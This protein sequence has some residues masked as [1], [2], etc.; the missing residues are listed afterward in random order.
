MLCQHGT[1]TVVD[2]EAVPELLPQAW[3]TTPLR[4]ISC[5]E[6][7]GVRSGRDPADILREAIG[8][9][10]KLPVGRCKSGLSP[11][12]PY[13]T[14]AEL[15][16]LCAAAS[17]HRRC[18]LTTHVAESEA[19]F[20]MFSHAKGSMY[21]WLAR[22]GRN[23]GDCGEGSPV[24]YLARLGYLKA[25]LLAVH[26][27]Y[28]GPEDARIL[29]EH[30]TSVVHCP[31]SHAYF[32][33]APF[34]FEELRA[35][36]VNVALGTDSLAS[37][38]CAGEWEGSS[39]PV[40][41]ARVRTGT[42]RSAS[43]PDPGEP[44]GSVN[45][46]GGDERMPVGRSVPDRRTGRGDHAGAVRRDAEPCRIGQVQ[47]KPLIELDLFAEMRAF[48]AVHPE[49]DP[50]WVLGMTTRNG[51]V[52]KV[53]LDSFSNPRVTGVN[54]INLPKGDELIEASLTDGT[55]DIVLATRNGMAIRFHEEKVRAMG[56]S[57]YG[58]KGINLEKGDECMGMVIIRRDSS[59]LVV[60]ENGYGKRSAISDYRV[61][62]RGGKGVINVKTSDRN[63]KVVSI[64][65][66]IDDDELILI[67]RKGIA[68]RQSVKQIKV[69]GR[70]T[71]GVR[72]I[73]LGKDDKVIDV[74]RLAIGD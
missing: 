66:V 54:A 52:K 29:G 65:E 2:I 30:G 10:D 5:L 12:A 47:P 9:L 70:N 71:Q 8:H 48:R 35:A 36:G 62:N 58:V 19:E 61:T 23:M 7:T 18:V 34:P 57:A 39:N 3:S 59:I 55:N 72:L 17:I 63:G 68:N 6:L 67:T 73:N 33:H 40:D 32:G 26:V 1:T 13:S 24:R 21:R 43:L 4:V 31:R 44:P 74:A 20:A 14:G 37:V 60:T 38:R 42:R 41:H 15:L 56:R 46:H 27:N 64:K 28:L 53:S 49:I 11:H 45:L 51:V 16:R 50:R 25:R 22:N 69:I